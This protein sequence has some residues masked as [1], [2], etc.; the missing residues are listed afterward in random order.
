L[1]RVKVE[2]STIDCVCEELCLKR[3]DFM[4][5]DVEGAELMALR[6]SRKTL[7][8]TR[9]IVVA[10]YHLVRGKA[11]W[12]SVKRFLEGMGFRTIVTEDGLVH[13]WRDPRENNW[14]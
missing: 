4:M 7:R 10:A 1:R 5:M 8:K 3:V 12:P 13:G 11:T 6:G 14:K 2:I 9:K